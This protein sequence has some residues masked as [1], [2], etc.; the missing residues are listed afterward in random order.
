MYLL[1]ARLSPGQCRR[2]ESLTC[3]EMGSSA[4][5]VYPDFF[6]KA[7]CKCQLQQVDEERSGSVI[8]DLELIASMIGDY[9]R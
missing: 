6:F 7:L 1:E 4:F 3:R 8:S 2:T 9:G 5:S